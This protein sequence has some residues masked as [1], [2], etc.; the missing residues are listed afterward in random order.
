MRCNHCPPEAYVDTPAPN[1][2]GYLVTHC[3]LCGRCLGQRP[4]DTRKAK[5][6]GPQ[7]ELATTSNQ[8]HLEG[9]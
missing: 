8:Y 7:P 9:M 6:K 1:R 4:V 3:K 5:A 2:P